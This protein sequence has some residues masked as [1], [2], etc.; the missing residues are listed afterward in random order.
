MKVIE[1]KT[2]SLTPYENNPRNNEAA[3]DSVAASIE[4]FGFRVPLVIDR[5][6][7]VV[8][9]HTRLLAA[10]KL[11]LK[12]VP[13]IVADDLSEAQIKAYRLVDNKVAEASSWDWD[14]L[15]EELAALAEFPDEEFDVD[16][17]AFGF[18][19]PGLDDEAGGGDI[20][21]FFEAAPD[22]P[23]ASTGE[24][25]AAGKKTQLVTCPHCGEVFEI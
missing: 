2:S 3:V 23:A 6:N 22:T 13:C 21:D 19:V 9:G 7:V 8:A 1:V 25:E 20:S 16:M 17:S 12:K 14:K 24:H 11:G 5:D 4:Q 18:N 10:Q 15:D